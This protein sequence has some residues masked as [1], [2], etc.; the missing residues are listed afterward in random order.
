MNEITQNKVR[1]EWL[2]KKIE[3]LQINSSDL[4]RLRRLNTI[5]NN[6]RKAPDPDIRNAGEA[7]NHIKSLIDAWDKTPEV[8]V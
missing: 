8:R 4:R 5:F 7:A 2:V 3:T 6:T 1:H